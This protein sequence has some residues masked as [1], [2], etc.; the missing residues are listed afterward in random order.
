MV[1]LLRR[2]VVDGSAGG[3]LNGVGGI[4]RRVAADVRTCRAQDASLAI[5]VLGLACGGPVSLF[6]LAVDD[7]SRERV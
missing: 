5:G 3:N 7:E 6:G 1:H 4:L 2:D